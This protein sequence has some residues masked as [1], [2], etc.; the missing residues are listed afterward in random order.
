MNCR[1]FINMYT[2]KCTL[3]PQAD[4]VIKKEKELK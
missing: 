4:Y 3:G 2:V 1:V